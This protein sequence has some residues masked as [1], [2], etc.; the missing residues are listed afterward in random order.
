MTQQVDPLSQIRDVTY[1]TW[2]PTGVG[3]A[4]VDSLTDHTAQYFR[5]GN[6]VHCSGRIE[7]DPTATGTTRVRIDLPIASTFSNPEECIGTIS[8]GAGGEGIVKAD[9]VN[10]EAEFFFQAAATSNRSFYYLFT[11]QLI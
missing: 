2:T 1:G 8:D 11:Y 10:D 5:I 6:L 4:N 9:A 3:V 7:V